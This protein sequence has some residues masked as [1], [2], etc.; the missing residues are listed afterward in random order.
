MQTDRHKHTDTDIH[1]D[2]QT[3]PLGIKLTKNLYSEKF[4][5]LKKRDRGRHWMG[6][7]KTFCVYV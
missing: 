7:G 3:L 5:T 2:T 4:K 1:T 6:N